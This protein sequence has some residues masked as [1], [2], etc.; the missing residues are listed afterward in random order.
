M[1][2]SGPESYRAFTFETRGVVK[3]L[4][5]NAQ[6]S[7]PYDPNQGHEPPPTHQAQAL[8]D[9]G[10]TNCAITE[11]LVKRVGLKPVG[12]AKVHGQGGEK[13]QN[14]YLLNVHLPNGVAMVGIRATECASTTGK[15]DL[16]I[17]M[18]IIAKGDFSVSSADGITKFSF[19]Y[20]AM[21]APDFAEELEALNQ[22]RLSKIG[23]NDKVKVKD[24]ESGNVQT[25]KW[26]RAEPLVRD[27]GWD[28]VEIL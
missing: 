9:T 6:V 27:D 11:E 21:K 18:D 20:P 24:R 28:L 22:A 3:E 4:I 14:V 10:A 25:M 7:V 26:K 1:L 23:R 8:W 19:R 12:R 16:I 15:F 2:N 5:T 17:G 13:E